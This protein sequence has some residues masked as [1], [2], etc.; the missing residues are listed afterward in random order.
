MLE[1]N[2]L[3]VD[4]CREIEQDIKNYR[5]IFEA[6]K[7]DKSLNYDIIFKSV[8]NYDNA[9]ETLTSEESV[10][11]VVLVDYNLS[12]GGSKKYGDELVKNIRESINKHCKIIFYTASNLQ[13]IF[14]IRDDLVEF[15]NLGIFKFLTKEL[16]TQNSKSY[17]G[18]PFNQIRVEAIIE[19]IASIDIVQLAVERYFMKYL[20]LTREDIIFI[21]G[22]DYSVEELI[23]AIR[24][25]EPAGRSFREN[26]MESVLISRILKG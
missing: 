21:D 23:K 13:E 17:G 18:T 24:R 20:S 7:K 25:D 2:V 1:R 19:A 16:K 11:D 14:P 8:E 3:I 26:L 6:I 9:I 5:I 22:Q 4:D 10:F 15:F 12:L